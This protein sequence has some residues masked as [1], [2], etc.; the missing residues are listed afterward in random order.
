MP[1]NIHTGS[2]LE[3]GLGT[4]I[5]AITFTGSLIAFAKLQ[6]LISVK[7]SMFAGQHFLNLGLGIAILLLLALFMSSSSALVF[8]LIVLTSLAL[9]FLLIL[10]IGGTDKTVVI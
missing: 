9:G 3:M 5:G 1:G 4:A 6:A 10:P 7:P 2:L 8:W